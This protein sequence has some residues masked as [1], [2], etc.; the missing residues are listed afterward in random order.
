MSETPIQRDATPMLRIAEGKYIDPEETLRLV[1][2]NLA[3]KY[4][5]PR[6]HPHVAF[7]SLVADLV[8]HGSGYSAALCHW[9]GVDPDTG[10]R[11]DT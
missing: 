10:M 5:R 2:L 11:L 3:A 4:A 1:I 9:A 6:S 7:W 8:G